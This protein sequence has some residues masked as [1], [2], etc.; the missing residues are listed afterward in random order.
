LPL[1][2]EY[3]GQF[4]GNADAGQ[5]HFHFGQLI[6]HAARTR[7][8]SAGTIIG[9]GTVSNEDPER[10]SSCLAEKRMIEQI[11]AGAIATPFMKVGDRIRIEMKDSRGRSIFGAID[12]RVAQ[13]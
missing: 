4:F 12:Q 13:A 10:G 3:N 2:V 8:L 6:A 7:N 5:M 9:S 1:S 11:H